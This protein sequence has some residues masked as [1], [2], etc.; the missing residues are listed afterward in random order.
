M[1][2]EQIKQI[3][4]LT[5]AIV[6]KRLNESVDNTIEGIIEDRAYIELKS[7]MSEKDINILSKLLNKLDKRSETAKDYDG[8]DFFDYVE[9]LSGYFPI[10]T[11]N[12]F[13]EYLKEYTAAV[14][15]NMVNPPLKVTAAIK[16]IIKNTKLTESIVNKRLNESPNRKLRE[17]GYDQYGEPIR[18]NSGGS[19]YTFYIKNPS[20]KAKINSHGRWQNVV[21]ER[22]GKYVINSSHIDDF[23]DFIRDN[24]YDLG[25]D[26][27][28]EMKNNKKLNENG[29]YYRTEFSKISAAPGP[30]QPKIQIMDDH[31]KTKWI[32]L[33][34][35]SVPEL[36]GWLQRTF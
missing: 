32:D 24:G 1:T 21:D 4:R 26:I 33:N 20:V 25:T 16:Q 14:E 9:N 22:N 36:I 19:L 23:T 11:A 34:N 6:N 2:R 28:F 5:E 18:R 30:T 12:D 15:D 13:F 17:D 31:A 3:V 29:S 35:D 7:K 8:N 27:I 10:D